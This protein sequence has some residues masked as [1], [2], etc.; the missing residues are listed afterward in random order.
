MLTDMQEYLTYYISIDIN[1]Y[2]ITLTCKMVALKHVIVMWNQIANTFTKC[3]VNTP[4]PMY[5]SVVW[6][7]EDAYVQ[8]Q[9][10]MLLKPFSSENSLMGLEPKTCWWDALT[11]ELPILLYT[12][13]DSRMIVLMRTGNQMEIFITFYVQ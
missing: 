1:V 10:Y 2:A 9:M 3:C 12:T 13:W 4:L 6:N 5:M 7:V 11:I 8:T